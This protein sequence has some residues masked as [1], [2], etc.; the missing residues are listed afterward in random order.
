MNGNCR[1]YKYY[2]NNFPTCLDNASKADTNISRD[3]QAVEC[4]VIQKVEK[5]REWLFIVDLKAPTI[6]ITD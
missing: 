2:P 4:P 1:S 6:F 5:V 3:I